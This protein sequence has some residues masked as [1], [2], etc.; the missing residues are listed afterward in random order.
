MFY[1]IVNKRSGSGKGA[2]TWNEIMEVLDAEHVSYK[3]WVTEYAGHA[4]TLAGE[5]CEKEDDDICLVA[6]GGDGTVNEVINGMRHFE[7]VRF[8][9]IPTG[10]GNDFA[11]GM[12]LSADASVNMQRIIACSRLAREEN[13]RMD[14][15]EVSFAGGEKPR[16]FAVSAGIGL[17]ALVCKKALTS[18]LKDFLNRLHAGKLTYVILTVQSLFSMQTMDA[19][20]HFDG[21]GGR[22]LKKTIFIAAMNFRCEGGGVPMAPDASAADGK[23]SVCSA[24]GIP[25]WRT[26]FCLPFLVAAKHLWIRGFEVNNVTE[27]SIR[28]KNPMVLH[29]DGEYCG[30][31][32]QLRFRCLPGKLCVLA[33]PHFKE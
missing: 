25:K 27:C 1:F 15:G 19:A 3:A 13:R 9:V 24:S 22:S 16:L 29:A 18:R 7:R 5:I 26:F 23:L 17:D 11:R 10:S 20:V 14:L 8:G 32:S 4:V 12:D 30:D 6:V 33:N 28:L 21:K 2:Q 31:V